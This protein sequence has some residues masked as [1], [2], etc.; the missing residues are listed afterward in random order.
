MH[1]NSSRRESLETFCYVEDI[2][3]VIMAHP[4]VKLNSVINFHFTL[5]PQSDTKDTQ[6]MADK[7][8]H[9][10][11]SDRKFTERVFNK[12]NSEN[13]TFIWSFRNDLKVEDMK[14]FPF[15][16]DFHITEH[17]ARNT[18]LPHFAPFSMPKRPNKRKSVLTCSQ[19]LII[20]I[21][22]IVGFS[23]VCSLFQLF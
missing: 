6:S 11:K 15:S 17:F 1:S 14:N 19:V 10:W 13:L 2:W 3:N 22:N 5:H 4:I 9:G 8:Y 21:G 16:W 7:P 12:K 18:F 20:P 23:N